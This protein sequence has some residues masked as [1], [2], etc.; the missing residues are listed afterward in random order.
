MTFQLRTP[1]LTTH[2]L[3][4][5]RE[6][7]MNEVNDFQLKTLELTTSSLCASAPL[8]PLRETHHERSE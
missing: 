4:P 1:E 7:I 2:K 3:L 8:R 6:T 5:L